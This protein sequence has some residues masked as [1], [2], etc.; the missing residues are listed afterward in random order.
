MEA[1]REAESV[2]GCCGRNCRT[3]R[4]S[5]RQEQIT[6]DPSVAATGSE[7]ERQRDHSGSLPVAAMMD[8]RD[9][10]GSEILR[11]QCGGSTQKWEQEER[12]EGN[13]DK[14]KDKKETLQYDC[15]SAIPR[16]QKSTVGG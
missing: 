8:Q 10:F 4:Q 9:Y 6:L 16:R 7:R 1:L 2:Q 5:S 15:C 12:Q 3:G 13:R 14:N 11:T